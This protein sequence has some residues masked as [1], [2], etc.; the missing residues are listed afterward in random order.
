MAGLR[1]NA[2]QHL[3]RI[4]SDETRSLGAFQAVH[5]AL[6]Y[7]GA[8]VQ[9]KGGR[10]KRPHIYTSDAHINIETTNKQNT[11]QYKEHLVENLRTLL[12]VHRNPVT[13]ERLAL[14]CTFALCAQNTRE[15]TWSQRK[16]RSHNLLL[17]D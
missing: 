3:M 17:L 6:G 1:R 15:S 16:A 5:D 14:G 2:V 8:G 13:V 11:S 4:C 7:E 12:L 9:Y 10:A